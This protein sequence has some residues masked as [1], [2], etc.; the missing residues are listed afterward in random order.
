MRAIHSRPRAPVTAS[1]LSATLLAFVH[2][3]G[4]VHTTLTPALPADEAPQRPEAPA[5]ISVMTWNVAW[6][7]DRAHGPTDDARQYAGVLGLLAEVDPSVVALQEVA[8]ESAFRRLLQD[9]PALAGVLSGHSATQKTALL[10]RADRFEL[11]WAHSLP[12]L[13]DAGRPPLEVLLRAQRGTAEILFVVIH[14]KADSQHASYLQRIEL[15]RGLKRYLDREHAERHRVLLGDFNDLL[16]DSL[17][18][19]QPSPYRD[20]IEDARYAAPT[21]ELR[22]G[23]TSFAHGATVD[24]ILADADLARA[25]EPGSVMVLRERALAQD[26]SFVDAVSDHFPVAL[27]AWW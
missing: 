8:S 14:A 23:A 22:E 4:C 11:V 24:H 20:F 6:F 2:G 27:R 19:G 5:P 13:E 26:P 3:L 16:V 12:G 7:Q 21:L 18:E 1:L 10:W 17:I 25:I 15:A 9:L